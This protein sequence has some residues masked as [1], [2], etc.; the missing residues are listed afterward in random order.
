MRTLALLLLLINIAFLAWQ[1]QLL[2]WLPWQPEQFLPAPA[3]PYRSTLPQL[4]LLS[5]REA[6]SRVPTPAPTQAATTPK[7]KEFVSIKSEP[8]IIAPAQ[9]VAVPLTSPPP[10]T[11]PLQVLEPAHPA[12][13]EKLQFLLTTE[14]KPDSPVTAPISSPAPV[15]AQLAP[16]VET[17]SFKRLAM[18]LINTGQVT[19][20]L[21]ISSA[22]S[23]APVSPKTSQENHAT[24]QITT[25]PVA[26]TVTPEAAKNSSTSA[27]KVAQPTVTTTN[28]ANKLGKQLP[29]PDAATDKT[30]TLLSVP[31]TKTNKTEVIC[32]Q[33]GVFSQ[34]AAVNAAVNWFKKKQVT[35]TSQGGDTRLA[36]TT[37][38]YLP[39][40]RSLQLAQ[41]TQQRLKRLGVKDTVI[42][43]RAGANTVSLGV[44]RDKL[45]V[46]QRLQE[47]RTKGF[48]DVRSEE[49]YATETK[50]WL[51]VKI[52]ANSAA[53]L[54]QFQKTFKGLQTAAVVC[55]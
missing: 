23:N 45:G 28:S 30:K 27:E 13:P 35:A 21:K 3:E 17:V 6:A 25:L 2:A 39:P 11:L 29:A 26:P 24:N 53:L 5:E 38:I 43:S 22:E 47:L 10:E 44:Y 48:N 55:K 32:Y 14:K 1:Q 16:A 34:P 19:S 42:I 37:W 51:S 20:P 52:A 40:V 46:T 15:T 8:A 36:T 50:Y 49:R 33:I 4:V 54:S 12:S 41:A 7:P 18:I 31:P 9:P